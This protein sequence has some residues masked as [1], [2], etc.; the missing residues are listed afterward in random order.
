MKSNTYE[1]LQ[2]FLRGHVV[3]VHLRGD[4]LP[5]LPPFPPGGAE[6][7]LPVGGDADAVD[8][9]GRPPEPLQVAQG[10][11]EGG[12]GVGEPFGEGDEEGEGVGITP[13]GRLLDEGGYELHQAFCN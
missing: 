9:P 1:L 7:M 12:A 8:A 6:Q 3:K 2:I 4:T 13:L 10:R 11:R 5:P